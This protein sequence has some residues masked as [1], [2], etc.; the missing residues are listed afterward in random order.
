MQQILEPDM[1]KSANMDAFK[2]GFSGKS[3]NG[4][5]AG[6]GAYVKEFYGAKSFR[7]KDFVVSDYNAV[8]KSTQAERKYGT[9]KADADGRGGAARMVKTHESKD[10]AVTEAR[11]AGKTASSKTH[12][13]RQI[14]WRGLSQDKM[15]REGPA[16]MAS[17]QKDGSFRK[18][19]TIDDIRKLLNELD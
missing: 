2:K 11:D 9:K 17:I 19:E 14:Q 4:R 5:N 18:L 3:F 7:G 8:R 12:D 15:D 10:Y 6:R 1:N 13:A 16:A